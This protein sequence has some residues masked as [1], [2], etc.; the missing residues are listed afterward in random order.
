MILKTLIN[1]ILNYL[2]VK[3]D[4]LKYYKEL[5]NLLFHRF[6]NFINAIRYIIIFK[7]Y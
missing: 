1:F 2:Y 3:K 6:H 4:K 7:T 5:K